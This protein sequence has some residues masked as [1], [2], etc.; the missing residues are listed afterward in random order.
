MHLAAAVR[1]CFSPLKKKLFYLFKITEGTMKL[2][3]LQHYYSVT[4]FSP[5]YR[6]RQAYDHSLSTELLNTGKKI[7]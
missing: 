6:L 2:N 1:S 4:E 3:G 7:K 5:T